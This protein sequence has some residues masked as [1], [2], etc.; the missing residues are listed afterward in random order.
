MD[1]PKWTTLTGHLRFDGREDLGHVRAAAGIAGLSNAPPLRCQSY[2]LHPT[3]Y[4]LHPTP[5]TL[6]PTPDTLHPTP[7]TPHP[8]PYTLNPVILATLK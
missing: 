8:T 6:H 1:F 3:P 5:Y 2:T 7:Y 4:T